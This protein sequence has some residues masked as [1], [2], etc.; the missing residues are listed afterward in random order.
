MI[1]HI[2]I[3]Q[4]LLGFSIVS[5]ILTLTLGSTAWWVASELGA[6]KDELAINSSAAAHQKQADMM[7]DGM[8][9]DVMAA[10][11]AGTA[12]DQE[13]G[14][15]II[16]EMQGHSKSFTTS[17][18]ELDAMI[19]PADIK[20]QIEKV[21]PAMNHYL[22]TTERF[23]RLALSDTK[24]A[25]AQFEEFNQSFS[26]LEKEM[27]DL[28]DF[29]Q[30]KSQGTQNAH[31]TKAGLTT[32]LLVSIFSSAFS[33]I[34]GLTMRRSIILP[35][36]QAV[37]IAQNVATGNFASDFV[38]KSQD[39]LGKL[40]TALRDMNGGLANAARQ[41]A[42]NMRLRSALD[43]A[44][45]N[46]M[47]CNQAH[48]IIYLN[49][50]MQGLLQ[51]CDAEL[52]RELPRMQ[53]SWLQAD[54]N[55]LDHG[56]HRFHDLLDNLS[57][58]T[59]CDTVLAKRHFRFVLTPVFLNADKNAK[60]ERIGSVIEWSDRTQEVENEAIAIVNARIKTALD[61]SSTSLMIVNPA[62]NIT[63][64][65]R[66][67]GKL[68][69]NAAT[70]LRSAM[71]QFDAAQIV[72]LQLAMFFQAANLPAPSLSQSGSTQRTAQRTEITIGKRIFA[73]TTNAITDESGQHLGNVLEWLDRTQ[74]IAI[75][76]QVAQVVQ[77][78]VQGDFTR[79]ITIASESRFFT[80]LIEGMNQ[81]MT[82]S[83]MGLNEVAR[84]LGALASGD[85]SQR[86]SND[87]AG[88]FGQLKEDANA[89]SARLSRI[90]D[91]VRNAA[92]TLSS[93]SQHLSLTA[94]SLSEAAHGQAKGVESTTDSVAALSSSVAQNSENAKITNTMAA[95]SAQQ[96]VQGGTAVTQTV[97]AMKQIAAKI[98]IVD[99]IAYQTNL[100]ALN[101]AIEAAR[102][103]EHGKGFAVVAAE[104]RKL[105]ERSQ[106]AAKEI[107]GLAHSS[108]AVS[109]EAGQLLSKMIPAIHKTSD[110][111][112]EIA[113][114]SKEQATGL[115][116]INGSMGNLNTIT[117]QNANSAKD[118]A[119]TA[120][121][122][123]AQ[124]NQLLDLM[125]FFAHSN[126]HKGK[127][128]GLRSS[129]GLELL[130]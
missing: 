117:Q 97:S 66:S 60:P 45:A 125:E 7:H 46:A 102:A 5:A 129:G 95:E 42:E 87:Y 21:R 58:T 74:E 68:F 126:R 36:N 115:I 54:I 62:G 27:G 32:I 17:I 88:T 82:T 9:G 64:T 51:Q 4:K 114:A 19:L 96:A 83:D 130:N 69:A 53:D 93:A 55:T 23:T 113:E 92:D 52:R 75:E 104:V 10:M 47:V 41:A 85:L 49:T 38:I 81:L 28:G 57:Q 37:R 50:A 77:A 35:L 84:V 33:L 79:R 106:V 6:A 78:A 112:Q 121:E 3:G 43:T 29:I 34:F 70:E 18:A 99:D 100:L 90:I 123:S 127:G 2:N 26:K 44:S 108:V 98:S 12:N 110:L 22:M 39:E 31:S 30:K 86:I 116:Q 8:R 94:Q 11:V 73:L 124:A 89:T 59:V 91:D 120:E 119:A 63:Y 71:P 76:S 72:G 65:N 80:A 105:A 20:G 24:A 122:M 56:N 13:R 1:K 15:E 14:K 40:L 111:V 107:G 16:K 128:M 103:G 61:N 101:A 109:E 118:L 48:S 67:M 25:G